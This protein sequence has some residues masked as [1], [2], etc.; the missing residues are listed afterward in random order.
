[1]GVDRFEPLCPGRKKQRSLRDLVFANGPVLRG[2][3]G[4]LIN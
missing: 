2:C 1:M 4:P 3:I